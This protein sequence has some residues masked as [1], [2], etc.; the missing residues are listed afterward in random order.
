MIRLEKE[1]VVRLRDGSFVRAEEYKGNKELAQDQTM[2][3]QIL[4]EHNSSESRENLKLKFDYLIS[5]DDNSAST[6]QTARAMGCQEFKIPWIFTNGHN[7]LA[8]SG[9]TINNDDHAFAYDCVRKY[10]GIYVPPYTAIIHQYMREAAAAGGQLILAGDSHTR[11]GCLG[12]MG[13]G[14]GGIELV[15][16]A[17]GGTYSLKRPEVIAIYLHGR[18]RP[19]IGSMDV[20]LTLIGATFHNGFNK[21]KILEFVGPGIENL[22]M[23]FRFGLDAMTTESACY[24]TIWM[25]DAKVKAWF[26]THGRP[27]DFREFA[28][29][30][31]AYYDGM[32]DIDLDTIES[33]IALPFHPSNVYSIRSLNENTGFLEDVLREVEK[34]AAELSGGL[35]YTLT[36]KVV[37]GRLMVQQATIGGCVG[38]TYENMYMAAEILKDY[39]ITH[40]GVPLGIYP[41]SQP[42]LAEAVRQGVIGKL[43]QTGATLHPCMCGPCFGT[44]DVPANNTLAIRHVSRNYYSREGSRP[45]QGQLS[46]SAIMDARSIAATIKH[47]GYLTA[48]T[49]LELKE[50]HISYGYDDSYYKKAVYQ[51]YGKAQPDTELTLGPNIADWP[52]MPKMKKYMLLRVAGC[53]AGSITTDELCPSGEASSLRSNPEKIAEFTLRSRDNNYVRKAKEF[54]DHREDDENFVNVVETIAKKFQIKQDEIGFG[55]MIVSDSVGDGSSREQAA[56]NQK[57]LGCWANLAMEYSTKRYRSNCI[58]WGLIPLQT[59]TPLPLEEGDYLFLGKAREEILGGAVALEAYIPKTD[60]VVILQIGEMTDEERAILTEG[61]MIN[62]YSI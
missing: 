33:M 51:G 18:L 55:S 25:T 11:Y 17:L 40:D 50:E 61:G 62:Y 9:G 1:P 21:N 20:A 48:A 26:A 45:D 27:G 15:K 7:P 19:G 35:S 4:K 30:D 53:Y 16:Q 13:I 47:G 12:A 58:G 31:D 56:S 5:P 43:I 36:D 32:I 52:Q 49:E 29:T 42:T 34:T 28:M 54:R 39:V 14:E 10:G 46:A 57:T 3:W 38:G 59:E 41:A 24:S 22:S 44:S 2:S 60:E 23:D 37:D 6:L 8:C